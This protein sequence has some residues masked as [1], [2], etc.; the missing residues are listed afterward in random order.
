MSSPAS[1]SP[2]FA[3]MTLLTRGFQLS[4]MIQVAVVLGLADHLEGG[5]QPVT[6]LAL[7]ADAD[8]AMLL[9]LC[10]ALAAFGIFEV[11]TGGLVAHTARYWATPHVWGSW[12][13]L[14]DAVRTGGSALELAY[15]MPKFEYL[16]LHPEEAALFDQLMQ[17]G[18]DDRQ[19]AVVAA[20][21]FAA[22][23]LVVDV[24]GG[25]GALLAAIL[26]AN[27]E[28]RGIL[29]DQEA[30]VAGA[31]R[32]LA[33]VAD[34]VQVEAGSFFEA[35]PSGGDVYTLSLILHDWDDE[36]CLNILANIRA[37]IAAGKRLLIVERV[38]DQPDRPTNPA[39]YLSDINMMVNL[40][41]RERTLPEFTSLLERSGFGK[42]VLHATRSPFCIL[43]AVRV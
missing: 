24:G 33:D 39:S 12:G 9:R 34:R 4:R 7:K 28:V 40:H 5:P 18:P 38:L 22:A 21:D 19:G 10:R 43:E 2:T 27:P 11:D 37:A 31:A 26:Q 29:F 15:G 8:P 14:E 35:V 16:K 6:V 13:H 30:V 17:H 41:G 23:G 1:G 20:Y 36:R 25:N 42:P 3:D 32:T